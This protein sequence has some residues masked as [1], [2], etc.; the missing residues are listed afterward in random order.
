MFAY[1]VLLHDPM[2]HKILCVEEPENQLY[3]ELMTPARRRVS[4]ICPDRW[5]AGFHFH[6]LPRFPDAI[7]LESLFLI[8]KRGGVSQILRV[9]DDPLVREQMEAG[10]KA[11]QLWNEGLFEGMGDRIG[12][13]GVIVILTE[14]PS[15][16]VALRALFEAQW[17]DRVRGVDWHIVSF[18]GKADL[19]R[20]M[21]EKMQSWNYG[22]PHFAYPS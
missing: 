5:R 20:R 2:P 7:E 10:F 1:M 19:E 16:S 3:P 12:E 13:G 11:G 8:E 18:R 14:E 22:S 4:G 21:I 17:P 6:A 15:M 9:A